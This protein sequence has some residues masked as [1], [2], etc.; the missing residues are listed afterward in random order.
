MEWFLYFCGKTEIDDLNEYIYSNLN[1]GVYRT[2]FASSQNAYESGVKNIFLSLEK[3]EKLLVDISRQKIEL[4]VV[5]RDNL[6]LKREK[7]TQINSYRN[8]L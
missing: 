4:E 2:G 6:N 5:L 1:N 8:I 3:I 7:Q